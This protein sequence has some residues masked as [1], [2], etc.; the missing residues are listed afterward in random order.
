MDKKPIIS[1]LIFLIILSIVPVSFAEDDKEYYIN[2]ATIDIYVLEN[3][4]LHVKETFQ[5]EFKGS[6]NG[7]YRDIPLVT[8]T[9]KKTKI[10][11]LKVSA[12]GAYTL[13]PSITFKDDIEKI[14]IYLS[15]SPTT[16]TKIKDRK[17]DVTLEYD[18]V[19]QT[20]IYNDIAEVHYKP[21]GDGW[22]KGVPKVTARFHLKSKDGVEY[23]VNPSY[24]EG[25]TFWTS[26]VLNVETNSINPYEWF[27]LR[28]LIPKNQFSNNTKYANIIPQDGKEKLKQ[29]QEEDSAKEARQTLIYTI[30]SGVLLISLVIPFLAYFFFGREPEIEYNGEYER[31]LPT[32][33]PPATVNALTNVSITGAGNPSMDGFKATVMDLINRKYFKLEDTSIEGD[34]ILNIN[35]DKSIDDLNEPEEIVYK[36][37]ESYSIGGRFSLNDFSENMKNESD[38]RDYRAKYSAWELSVENNIGDRASSMFIGTG[39]III[40]VYAVILLIIS[41]ICLFFTWDNSLPAAGRLFILCIPLII[42]SFIL[43]FLPSKIGGRWTNEGRTYDAKWNNFKRYLTDFSMIEEYPPES[44]TVWNHYLVYATAL[45]VAET[46]SEHMKLSLPPEQLDNS[47]LYRFHYYGGYSVLGTSMTLGSTTGVATSSSV[48][49]GFGGSGGGGGGGGGGAF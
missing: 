3:G 11:N 25:T 49:G 4:L 35:Y 44:V 48:G 37:F 24:F 14:K 6:W 40:K 23:W 31:E 28:I 13:T 19:N 9:G 47:D 18:F 8:G 30:L 2:G 42:I 12:K 26:N 21:W 34:T 46:V 7:V 41:T 38:A 43:L 20:N 27:E 1:I 16:R 10:S 36:L 22:D 5:Y 33:D 15:S 39:N 17:V 32:N 45:G 29:I